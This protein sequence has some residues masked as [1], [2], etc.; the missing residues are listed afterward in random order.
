VI[1]DWE[2]ASGTGASFQTLF[3]NGRFRLQEG[4]SLPDEIVDFFFLDNQ[5][6]RIS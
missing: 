1:E 2:I 4:I 5:V 3:G 6:G